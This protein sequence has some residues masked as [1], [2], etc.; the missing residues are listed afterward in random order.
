[1]I[2]P[3]ESLSKDVQDDIVYLLSDEGLDVS[4]EDPQTVRD[5]LIGLKP[6]TPVVLKDVDPV[7]M[8]KQFGKYR[9]ISRSNVHHLKSLIESGVKLDPIITSNG[10]FLDGGHRVIAFIE[11]KIKKI[12]AVDI[13]HLVEMNWKKWLAGDD[14]KFNLKGRA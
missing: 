6:S 13:G 11:L 7:L 3:I 8:K 5:N 12:P 10:R 2:I 14:V 1:M 9:E 4:R